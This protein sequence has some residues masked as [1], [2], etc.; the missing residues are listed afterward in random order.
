[1]RSSDVLD[2]PG[3]WSFVY[4]ERFLRGLRRKA[5]AKSQRFPEVFDATAIRRTK[6]IRAY[7]DLVTAPIHGFA[8]ARDY[9]DKAS[10]GRYLEG[11]A[12]PLAAI[13]AADDPMVP[14]DTL[15]RDLAARSRWLRLEVTPAGGHVAFVTGGPFWPSYWAERRAATLL[16][17]IARD[18]GAVVQG[19]VG[20]RGSAGAGR[21]AGE[22]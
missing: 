16:A 19:E 22:R 7:D 14:P 1:V 21:L 12:R 20:E 6:T 15:P 11:L 5:I 13:A 8:S 17:G 2:G 4:R 18:A 9:Y 3:F 10:C